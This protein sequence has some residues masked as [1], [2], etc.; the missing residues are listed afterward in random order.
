MGCEGLRRNV[1]CVNHSHNMRSSLLVDILANIE[2]IKSLHTN[3]LLETTGFRENFNKKKE[4]LD[5]N[6]ENQSLVRD[7]RKFVR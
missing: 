2:Y 1:Q 7:Y 4:N 3:S 6:Y 5:K